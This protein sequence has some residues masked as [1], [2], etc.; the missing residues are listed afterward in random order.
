MND[1]KPGI[2]RHYKGNDY[3]VIGIAIHSETEE[4]HVVYRA[5]YGDYTL[6]IRPKTMFAEDVE[7]PD[8]KGPRFKLV[9]AF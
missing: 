5:L 6:C 3:E 1:I 2:Y 4:A 8:Y 9:K 7:K